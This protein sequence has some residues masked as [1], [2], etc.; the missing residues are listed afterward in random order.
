MRLVTLAGIGLLTAF[1]C[2]E[3]RSFAEPFSRRSDIVVSKLADVAGDGNPVR[4]VKNPADKKLYILKS[5]GDIYLLKK[6]EGVQER[7]FNLRDHGVKNASGMAIGSDGAFYLVG[8]E[9]LSD[10]QTIGYVQKGKRNGNG[11]M[12]WKRVATSERYGKSFSI[13]NHRFNGVVVSPDNQFIVVNSGSRTDHGE[14]QNS[15]GFFPRNTREMGLTAVLLKIPV[16][17]GNLTLPNDRDA[18]RNAGLLFA[19]G[20]RNTYD[21]AFAPNGDLFGAENSPDIDLPEELNWLRE[22]GHYGFP[23]RIGGYDNPQQFDDYDP[24]Q[25]TLLNPDYNA[26]RK[27]YYEN[28]PNFPPAPERMLEPVLNIGPH[29]DKYRDPE[30][31]KIKDAT[32]QNVGIRTFTA[33][34]SPLGI[35]FDEDGLLNPEFR[36]DAFMLSWTKG[37]VSSTTATGPFLDP[38]QDLLHI[39]LKKESSGENYVARVTRLVGGFTNPIDSVMLQNQLYVIEYGGSQSV[40]KVV[41]PVE[42]VRSS[43]LQTSVKRTNDN[44]YRLKVEGGAAASEIVLF[45][46]EDLE[47]W[48]AERIINVDAADQG[49]VELDLDTDD[50][51]RFFLVLN[52]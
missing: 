42:A 12:E 35:S 43:E 19:E 51:A 34:R 45:T 24:D 21:L 39:D 9:D 14:I 31:G 30:D 20:I 41:F 48:F 17:A 23:W 22:G 2:L 49:R 40:W 6:R 1:H 37:N 46:S 29:A 16:T 13:F 8:Y 5:N 3:Q 18:L 15:G 25:D 38:S 47:N 36:G 28:D 4:L 44:R 11:E 52:R 27:N 32:D 50:T 7:M 26:V 10:T 33:H